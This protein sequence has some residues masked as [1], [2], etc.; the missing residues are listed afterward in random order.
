MS[1]ASGAWPVT[2][3]GGRRPNSA[4]EASPEMRSLHSRRACRSTDRACT[5]SQDV[6]NQVIV[7][8]V[9]EVHTVLCCH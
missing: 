1:M 7:A 9:Q 2:W 8:G 6:L 3:C 5:G 4:P